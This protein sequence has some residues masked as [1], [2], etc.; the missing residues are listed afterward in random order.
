MTARRIRAAVT[1]A[2]AAL[3]AV[4][5]ACS[6]PSPKPVTWLA[7]DL[8][9]E[10]GRYYVT[11]ED[12]TNERHEREVWVSEEQA[13][14]HVEDAPCPD[15]EQRRAPFI[16]PPDAE[17]KVIVVPR[18]TRKTTTTTGVGPGAGGGKT[19]TKAPTTTTSK[20]TTR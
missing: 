13:A 18:P 14:N 11:C 9:A 2:A 8:L 7:D 5:A 16:E 12:S 4:T 3:A 20:R 6:S 15:G 10:Q 17:A 19:T 1:M